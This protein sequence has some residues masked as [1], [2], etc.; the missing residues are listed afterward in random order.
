VAGVAAA[1]GKGRCDVSAISYVMP[2]YNRAASLPAAAGSVLTQLEPGD[3]L[4]VVDDG[5]SDAT[6]AVLAALADRWG[7][8]LVTLRQDNAGPGAARNRGL[9]AARNDWIGFLDSDDE[10]LPGAVARWRRL[11]AGRPTGGLLIAGRLQRES[12]GRERRMPGRRLP[13]QAVRALAAFLASDRRDIGVGAV[14]VRRDVVRRCDFPPD[15]PYGEDSV[16]IARALAVTPSTAIAE[17]AYRYNLDLNRAW[18]RPL[19]GD[20]D[21]EHMVDLMF[22]PAIVPPE[23]QPLKRRAL[24]AAWLSVFRDLHRRGRD[25][26]ALA[27]WRRA[28]RRAPDLALRLRH[29]RKVARGLVGWRHRASRRASRA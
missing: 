15:L 3:E 9:A 28:L 26:E 8:L 22:D 1:G 16:F 24:A 7:G 2:S 14:L 23:V 21:V 4:I 29:L 5:S 13:P 11:I 27:Y 10:L 18:T 17:P 20:F 6:P 12:D 25:A 19:W